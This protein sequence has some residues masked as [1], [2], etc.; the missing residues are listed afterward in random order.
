MEILRSKRILS[1]R[2]T[3]SAMLVTYYYLAL[4]EDASEDSRQRQIW[5]GK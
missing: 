4:Q 2:S 5:Y 3:E 1:L